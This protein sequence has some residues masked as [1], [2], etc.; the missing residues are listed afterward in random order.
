M[1]NWPTELKI[2][3]ASYKESPPN[4]SIRSNMETG[5]DKIRR[6]STAAIRPISFMLF[7]TEDQIDILDDFYVTTLYSGS[8]SFNLVH[9]RTGATVEARFVQPPEYSAEET[10]HRASCSLEILS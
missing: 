2:N 10:M 7:L 4:N 3:R 6:R 8:L 5:P 1:A 9:P